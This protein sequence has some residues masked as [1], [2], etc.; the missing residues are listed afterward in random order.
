MFGSSHFVLIIN[1]K[2]KVDESTLLGSIRDGRTG[3]TVDL[4]I[5]MTDKD[6]E[7]QLLL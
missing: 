3:Q 5:V 6:G 7:A 2:L 4:K 1:K